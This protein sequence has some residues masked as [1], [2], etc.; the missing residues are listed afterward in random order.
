MPSDTYRLFLL[1]KKR[2]KLMPRK[3]KTEKKQKQYKRKEKQ[4]GK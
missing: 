3:K 4:N 1:I 2:N